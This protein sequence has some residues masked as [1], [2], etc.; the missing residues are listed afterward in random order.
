MKRKLNLVVWF[1]A[2]L[3][4]SFSAGCRQTSFEGAAPRNG[5]V[6]VLVK[7][8]EGEYKTVYWPGA[9]SM[10]L[11]PVSSKQGEVSIKVLVSDKDLKVKIN[12]R[13]ISPSEENALEF[14]EKLKLTRGNNVIPI[15]LSYSGEG[16][17]ETFSIH[18]QKKDAE[19]ALRLTHLRYEYKGKKSDDLTDKFSFEGN[20]EKKFVSADKIKLEVGTPNL[21]LQRV[22]IGSGTELPH[23]PPVPNQDY[24]VYNFDMDNTHPTVI[25]IYAV[26]KLKNKEEAF[27]IIFSIMDESE[28]SSA[29]I[30]AVKAV[31]GYGSVLDFSKLDMYGLRPYMKGRHKNKD[32]EITNIFKLKDIVF[33][34]LEG[35][36]LSII[37]EPEQPGAQVKL[38]AKWD[39]VDHDTSKTAW[40]FGRKLGWN[41]DSLIT[42]INKFKTKPSAFE[43]VLGP[44][45][46]TEFTI[47]PLS[48]GKIDL[49]L[50]VTSP[51]GKKKKYH[52]IKY[53]FVSLI[54][55][56][57]DLDRIRAVTSINDLGDEGKL[58]T[59]MKATDTENKFQV[60][61][62]AGVKSAMICA[63]DTLQINWATGYRQSYEDIWDTRAYIKINDGGYSRIHPSS[64]SNLNYK[65][66]KLS[67]SA[68]KEEHDVSIVTYQ[69]GTLKDGKFVDEYGNK[70]G[71]NKIEKKFVLE[72][73]HENKEIAPALSVLKFEGTVTPSLSQPESNK[74]YIDGKTYPVMSFRPS[75]SDY[76]VP[77]VKSGVNYKLLMLKTDSQAKIFVDGK[78]VNGTT[79]INQ[80]NYNAGST[81]FPAPSTINGTAA[82]VTFF[83][84]ELTSPEYTEGGNLKACTIEVIVKK[85]D[86]FRSYNLKIIPV[87]PDTNKTEVLVVTEN[88]GSPRTGTKVYY[89]EH[90]GT[91]EFQTK[92]E[93]GQKIFDSAT[94]GYTELGT[95]DANGKVNGTGKLKAGKYYDIYAL[96]TEKDIADSR[97]ENY[98]VKGCENEV[99]S[100]VQ[101]Y[102][103][104]NGGADYHEGSSAAV[105]RNAPVIL[106]KSGNGIYFYAREITSGGGGLGGK[107]CVL[108]PTNLSLGNAHLSLDSS[109]KMTDMIMWFDIINNNSVEPVSWAGF[110]AC[111][112]ID[113]SAHAF[114]Y[115]IDFNEHSEGKISM[116]ENAVQQLE[117]FR[118]DFPSGTF[119]FVIVAYDVA[120]NRIERHQF[121]SVESKKKMNGVPIG[122]PDHLKIEEFGVRLF[123]F[124]LKSGLFETAEHLEKLFGVP[125]TSYIATDSTVKTMPSSYLLIANCILKD[126]K[127]Y[128][129]IS[130]LDLYRRCVEDGGGFQ[131]V[132][133]TINTRRA[134]R[135][136]CIDGDSKLEEGKTYQYKMVVFTDEGH[137]LETE[138]LS[139]IKVP[140]AFVYHLDNISVSGQGGTDEHGE[141][142][143]GKTVKYGY[144]TEKVD[145][146]PI[147][148]LKKYPKHTPEEDKTPLEIE[149]TAKLS[150]P[151]L[152]CKEMTDE[153]SFGLA[154]YKRSGDVVYASKGVVLFED[155]EPELYLYS[156]LRGR[157]MSLNDL[158][159]AGDIPSTESFESLL[160]FDKEKG[161]LTFTKKYMS[162]EALNW[163]AAAFGGESLK[164][165]AGNTYYW[166]VINWGRYPIGASAVT[167][168]KSF[169]AVKK[170]VPYEKFKDDDGDNVPS[171]RY[172]VF[173]NTW[174]AGSNAL[175]GRCRFTVVQE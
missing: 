122:D 10:V 169:D 85:G 119:D 173:G 96:G 71:V 70:S 48:C 118:F 105:R 44:D 81:N 153:V 1:S 33:A 107:S 9:R 59:L 98:Y 15:N 154:I 60:F 159:K 113:S 13:R 66:I 164:Y 88:G 143:E 149:Y 121:V 17:E 104:Q 125:Y 142:L 137:S 64:G 61:L 41:E 28:A 163:N 67:D 99:I 94:A 127:D 135:F 58:L 69:D 174:S 23:A 87:D 14:V 63:D 167:F 110:G 11:D 158:I 115:K 30:K 129:P 75:V 109:S 57:L 86:A 52:E 74:G 150:N 21:E 51:N 35:E 78:E 77:L 131:K 111:V 141:P 175:N 114:G 47:T 126:G 20:L 145:T 138:Y 120:G 76:E 147:L 136:G 172:L 168:F 65:E 116:S 8:D 151:S 45:T 42:D 56:I 162:L 139:E 124:P 3:L 103:L 95:T 148:K 156:P 89:K 161:L 36:K 171:A 38:I 25:K 19:G 31:T 54:A 146:V 165:E 170:D 27:T 4:I 34:P 152:W 50:E 39:E 132:G 133:S 53:G 12:N 55:D 68:V 24:F 37:V 160:K 93:G 62:P 102:L 101:H 26:D 112:C 73:V 128:V 134:T 43:V 97:I 92:D 46:D 166:D 32:V 49:L 29:K 123:R 72:F 155:E 140:P 90:N 130:G 6:D 80:K 91:E 117:R 2:V 108:T 5:I 83:S 106:K 84:H 7:F 79:V 82:D 16:E 100:I 144:N 18:I 40:K 157:Y 22:E